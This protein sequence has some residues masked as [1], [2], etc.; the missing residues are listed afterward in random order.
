MGSRAS[1][2]NKPELVWS[3]KVQCQARMR[4]MFKSIDVVLREHRRSSNTINDL[5]GLG[6]QQTVV[7]PLY[8][9]TSRRGA[10]DVL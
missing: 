10:D 3:S 4:E 1:S 2:S 6:F 7:P 9:Q 5:A 8:A